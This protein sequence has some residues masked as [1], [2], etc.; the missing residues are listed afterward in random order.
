MNRPAAACTRTRRGVDHHALE[1]VEHLGAGVLEE[2]EHLARI[3]QGHQDG[4]ESFVLS[5]KGAEQFVVMPDAC[6]PPDDYRA[7]TGFD[8][9]GFTFGVGATEQ[10]RDGDV[11]T[12]GQPRQGVEAA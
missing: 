1:H 6:T 8:E 3:R 10:R 5:P 7:V 2:R 11:E 4:L 9:H 12:G